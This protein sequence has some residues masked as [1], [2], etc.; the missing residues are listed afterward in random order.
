MNFTLPSRP[1][2]DQAGQWAPGVM[3]DEEIRAELP[4]ATGARLQALA[5]E[6]RYR[7]GRDGHGDVGLDNR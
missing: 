5:D 4:R 3:S 2:R 1:V 7:E 6:R